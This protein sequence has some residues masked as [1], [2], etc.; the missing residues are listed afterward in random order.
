MKQSDRAEFAQ[1]LTDVLAYY[2]QDASKFVLDLWW[3]ACAPFDMEQVRKAMTGHATDAERGMYAPKVADI[4]R[5]LGG[6]RTDR[7]ALAWG[8]VYEAMGRV[9]AYSDVIFDDPAIHAVI[10]DLGG[11]PKVCRYPSEELSYL[12]HQFCT[13]HKAYTQAGGHVYPRRLMGDRSPDSEYERKGLPL[14]A[15]VVV[16]DVEAARA[17][18][19]GGTLAGKTMLTQLASSVTGALKLGAPA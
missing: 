1:L 16:G 15:P 14:P 3:T 12:Q 19:R 17:V 9:G 11:W 8:R 10:E 7:A 6:T 13:A 5:Q 4:V 18:Y 2:R